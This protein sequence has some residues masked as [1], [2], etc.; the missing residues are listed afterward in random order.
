MLIIVAVTVTLA[1]NGGL[2]EKAGIASNKY[3]DEAEKENISHEDMFFQLRE[4]QGTGRESYNV[5]D[6]KL[7]DFIVDGASLGNQSVKEYGESGYS[8]ISISF[9]NYDKKVTENVYIPTEYKTLSKSETIKIELKDDYILYIYAFANNN[10]SGKGNIEVRD[11]ETQEVKTTYSLPSRKSQ[12]IEPLQVTL[13]KGV[14]EI[15]TSYDTVIAKIQLEPT[16]IKENTNPDSDGDSG[17][18]D[19]GE[20]EG[21]AAVITWSAPDNTPEWLNIITPNGPRDDEAPFIDTTIINC[22]K[23]KN[24]FSINLAEKTYNITLYITGTTKE[25]TLTLDE[26]SNFSQKLLKRDVTGQSPIELENKTG[27]LNF[28]VSGESQIYKVILTEVK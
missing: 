28:K 8:S 4:A 14:Y 13:S 12:N 10:D 26:D 1:I 6:E 5:S 11:S 17:N 19:T 24:G 25:Q 2:F 22:I 18:T 15:A 21:S 7:G 3:K 16:V 23:I 20:G 27:T 9:I